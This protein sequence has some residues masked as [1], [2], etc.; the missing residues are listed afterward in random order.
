VSRCVTDSFTDRIPGIRTPVIWA[1]RFAFSVS[2]TIRCH[3]F[4]AAVA[5]LWMPSQRI[6]SAPVLNRRFKTS[7]QPI[8]ARKDGV[9][10]NGSLS[11]E[12]RMFGA[13]DGGSRV[14]PA[15]GYTVES[16]SVR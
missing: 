6:L 9:M 10:Q 14:Q 11:R 3:C 2:P 13:T 15:G 5:T 4:A 12:Q 16:F 8:Q 7:A 1:T